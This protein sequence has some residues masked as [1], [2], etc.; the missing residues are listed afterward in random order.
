MTTKNPGFVDEENSNYDLSDDSV[1]YS[2]IEG[3]EKIAP[4][5]EMG[6]ITDD[7]REEF[8]I[9]DV[10]TLY[11]LNSKTAIVNPN[12]LTLKWT[13][14]FGATGYE[15]VIA[16]DPEFENVI[17]DRHILGINNTCGDDDTDVGT[18]NSGID[19]GSAKLIDVLKNN[20]TYYWKVRAYSDVNAFGKKESVS[21]VATFK[22]GSKPSL[23]NLM[24]RKHLPLLIA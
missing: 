8:N 12:G 14:T 1:A 15:V 20:K 17:Y 13:E 4:I 19:K 3:F 2:K 18:A 10:K 6:C 5:S 16:S 9:G 11:P 21:P 23:L 24:R 22:I 7:N